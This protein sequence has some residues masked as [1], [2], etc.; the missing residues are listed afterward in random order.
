MELNIEVPA[1]VGGKMEDKEVGD[2][3]RSC[4]GI[5]QQTRTRPPEYIG[6]LIRKLV[7]E[8]LGS[9]YERHDLIRVLSDFGIPED[10][11]NSE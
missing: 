6:D 11:W 8:R 10:Q 7:E 4:R 5:G 3:W 2:L 9:P 1:M